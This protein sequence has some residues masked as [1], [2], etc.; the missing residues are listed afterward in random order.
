[1]KIVRAGLYL[2]F[3]FAV[4]AHGVVEPWS[5]AI[6]ESGAAVLLLIWAVDF[7]RR[8]EGKIQWS[9]LN[10]W[11]LCFIAI[12]LGQLVFHQTVNPY[13]TRVELLKYAAY[14]M[15]FF[16]AT[17]AFRER[18]HL[19]KLAWFLIFLGFGVSL[20]GIIQHFTSN[21]K[22]Y[23]VRETAV[24]GDIF[25]PYVNRN[26]FAGFVELVLPVG[27]ALLVFRGVRR[28][29]FPM[30]ALLTIVPVGALILSGSR[31]GIV[32]LGFEVG[33]LALLAKSRRGPEGPR[34]AALAIVAMA[35]VALIA[36]LGVAEVME[37]FA[38]IP[39]GD[40]LLSR[41]VTMIRGGLGVFLEHPVKGSGIG[42]LVT[43]YPRYEMEYDGKVVDHAHND[44]VETLADS[45]I[46]GGLCGAL[47]LWTLSREARKKF[48]EEQGHFSRGLHAAGI[49]AVS[50][51]L[52]HSLVD[53]NMHIPSN[54]LLFRL[55]SY[56]ATGPWFPSAV[57]PRSKERV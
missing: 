44:Y 48:S 40:V 25:G 41:R 46:L 49:M 26:H 14:F 6:L 1:M 43:S 10:V 32:G 28:D 54:V 8:P 47:F 33:V 4:L 35:A 13:L 3:T 18:V 7:Y 51:L 37:R 42:T 52:L 27:L 36:W 15:V 20:L 22:V 38:T 39:K 57:P 16:L 50:G 56:L 17:Q 5:E 2:V 34:I 45:G 29:V 24:G 19:T 12:G 53:F 21:G 30:T 11:I 55:M 31:G 23:W 9:P